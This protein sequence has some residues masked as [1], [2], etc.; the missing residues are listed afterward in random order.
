[1]VIPPQALA[2]MSNTYRW[3]GINENGATIR[4]A[5]LTK[6]AP[7]NVIGQHAWSVWSCEPCGRRILMFA[8]GVC[9]FV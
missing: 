1:M 8:G 7:G 2:L 9:C 3:N 6:G 4:N 5:I